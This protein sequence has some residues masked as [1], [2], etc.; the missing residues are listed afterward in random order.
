MS[1]KPFKTKYGYL[2]TGFKNS[3]ILFFIILCFLRLDTSK[4]EDASNYHKSIGEE[5]FSHVTNVDS[6][7]NT[8]SPLPVHHCCIRSSTVL[9]S[10]QGRARMELSKWTHHSSPHQ[11]RS[12]P[13]RRHG[14]KHEVNTGRDS[15]G[16]ISFWAQRSDCT[17][18]SQ[19]IIYVKEGTGILSNEKKLLIWP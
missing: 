1:F 9:G 14:E 2:N 12:S 3:F 15:L 11:L 10:S 19:C 17:A 13:P 8:K 18:F 7:R 6:L 4:Y 16:K 5:L